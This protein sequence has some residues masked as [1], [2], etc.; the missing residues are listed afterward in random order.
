MEKWQSRHYFAQTKLFQTHTSNYDSKGHRQ[1]VWQCV[2]LSPLNFQILR[3]PEFL[4]RDDSERI[5]CPCNSREIVGGSLWEPAHLGICVNFRLVWLV[6]SLPDQDLE[7]QSMHIS[8]DWNISTKIP[9]G[10]FPPNHSVK[11]VVHLSSYHCVK[12][13]TLLDQ[14]ICKWMQSLPSLVLCARPVFGR[15]A[16]HRHGG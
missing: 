2:R 8:A 3:V 13:V 14:C 1:H 15:G 11:P 12:D 4:M 7:K 9:L 10:P 5:Q 16:F 6:T